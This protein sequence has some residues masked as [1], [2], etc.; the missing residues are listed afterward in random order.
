MIYTPLI[1]KA[2]KICWKAHKDQLDKG[3]LPYI[4][5][6]Y[7]IAEQMTIET[8]II[9]ALLHDVVEDSNYTLKD[10]EQMGFS[11]D[12]IDALRAITKYPEESYKDYIYRVSKN[13]IASKVKLED[14]LHNSDLNRLSC[15]NS[16]DLDRLDKYKSAAELL[17]EA[18]NCRF[19]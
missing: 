19:I 12:I 3:G 8:E 16:D 15:V 1:K 18:E 10:I 17:K 4:F 14:L 9:V 6:P 11:K 13:P 5:H 7:H 2:I